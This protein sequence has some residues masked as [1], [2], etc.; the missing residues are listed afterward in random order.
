MTQTFQFTTNLQLNQ[1]VPDHRGECS[2]PLRGNIARVD[3][4]SYTYRTRTYAVCRIALVD[5]TRL[6]RLMRYHAHVAYWPL[7][8]TVRPCADS[9][10]QSRYHV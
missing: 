6:A 9:L 10:P 3:V 4:P 2:S 1:S 5:T 8:A 7:N